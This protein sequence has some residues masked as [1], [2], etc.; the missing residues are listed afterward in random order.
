MKHKKRNYLRISILLFLLLGFLFLHFYVPRFITEIKNPLIESFKR[1]QPPQTKDSFQNTSLQGKEFQITSF[2]DTTISCYL[3]YSNLPVTKGTIILLHGIRSRKEHFVALS[4]HLSLLGYNAVAVDLRAHGQS[5]GTHCT[6]GVKEKKDISKLVDYLV[7]KEKITTP[8]GVWGQSLGGAIGLQALGN[9]KRIAFGI[10]E[11][12]FT[13]FE[14]ITHDYFQFHLG[15][16]FK[17][18]THYLV[19]RAGKIADFNPEEAKPIAYCEKITQPILLVHGNQDQRIHIQ[20]AKEN[21]AAIPSS[22]KEFLEINQAN[23]LNVW[24]VGGKIY[25]DKVMA[26]IEKN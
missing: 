3:T 9:D 18:L 16:N 17:P 13:D 12:T 7:E 15:F 10:I 22:Q 2:D 20:Y 6:F 8:I 25:F 21:Y 14:T 11:S 19:H 1:K 26:F 4:Q 24:K 23:H 5:G